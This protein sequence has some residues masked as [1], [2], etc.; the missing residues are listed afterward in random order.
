MSEVA[1]ANQEATDA[2][3]GPLFDRFVR[4][5]PPQLERTS[6]GFSLSLPHIRLD[7]ALEFLVGDRLS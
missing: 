3:S 2:W 6:E 7:R 5:R 1:P 4:F